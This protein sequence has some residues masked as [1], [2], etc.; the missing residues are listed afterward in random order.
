M[1]IE[2]VAVAIIPRES[3]LARCERV[4][5]EFCVVNFRKNVLMERARVC[6]RVS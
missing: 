5:F 2:G 3:Y 6:C 4:F 1:A